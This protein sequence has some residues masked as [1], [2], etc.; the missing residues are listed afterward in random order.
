MHRRNLATLV[1]VLAG[2]ACA[3]SQDDLDDVSRVTEPLA[4]WGMRSELVGCYRLLDANGAA[5]DSNAAY[6]AFAF[7]ELSSA[8]L[9]DTVKHPGT[10]GWRA[11]LHP[12]DQPIAS[13]HMAFGPMWYSDSLTDTL[14]LSFID[15][16]SGAVLALDAPP[17]AVDSLSGTVEEHWDFGPSTTNRRRATAT[18]AECPRSKSAASAK[19]AA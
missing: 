6:N 9:N 12:G 19:G 10:R 13:E 3:P 7:V 2:G 15:G 16:F 8:P 1:I 5:L 14:R 18:R 17:G 4:R 11:L